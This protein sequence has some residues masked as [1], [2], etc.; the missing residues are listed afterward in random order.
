MIRFRRTYAIV[1]MISDFGFNWIEIGENDFSPILTED[2]TKE[3]IVWKMPSVKEHVPTLTESV[4]IAFENEFE[5]MVEE[6]DN[7]LIESA[8]NGKVRTRHVLMR[9]QTGW[10]RLTWVG[11]VSDPFSVEIMR[12]VSGYF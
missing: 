3:C 5:N 8:V 6:G 11:L 2:L 7:L 9:K 12:D 1:L 10:I 4:W